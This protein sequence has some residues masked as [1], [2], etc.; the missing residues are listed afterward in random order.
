MSQAFARALL[1]AAADSDHGCIEI[2]T[3]QDYLAAEE[4]VQDL[5]RN[6]WVVGIPT[7]RGKPVWKIKDGID[8]CLM[9]TLAGRRQVNLWAAEKVSS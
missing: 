7:M 8:Y 4:V 9:I 1:S 5:M 2:S 6:G 3:V